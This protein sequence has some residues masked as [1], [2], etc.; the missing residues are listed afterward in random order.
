MNAGSPAA[1]FPISPSSRRRAFLQDMGLGFGSVALASM[2]DR[3]ASGA[4]SGRAQNG[5]RTSF[6]PKAKNVIWLF[7]IGGASHMESFDPK[8]ALTRYAGRTIE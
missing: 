1:Q 8:P 6:A 4:E 5:D 7:M 2:L 3:E